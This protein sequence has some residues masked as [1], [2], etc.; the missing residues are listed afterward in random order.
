MILAIFNLKVHEIDSKSWRK[1][2]RFQWN[3]LCDKLKKVDDPDH[4]MN[5]LDWFECLPEYSKTL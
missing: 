3:E 5:M 4:E 2:R 1:A